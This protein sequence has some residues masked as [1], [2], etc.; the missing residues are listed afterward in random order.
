[1]PEFSMSAK[2]S[3]LSFKLMTIVLISFIILGTVV[4][5][6][7][8]V[9]SRKS[10]ET[11]NF[12]N[13]N[14]V[15]TSQI[16]Y[17]QNYFDML[18][19]TLTAFAAQEGTVIAVEEFIDS[20][21]N[22]FMY[23]EVNEQDMVES[24]TKMYSSQFVNEINYNILNSSEKKSI[25]SYMPDS[26]S[27]KLLQH[28]AI[29]KNPKPF[30]EKKDV[31]DLGVVSP[32]NTAHMQYHPSFFN[33]LKSFDVDDIFLIDTE[34]TVVYSVMKKVDF[35]T[36]LEFGPYKDSG[37]AE[38]YSEV[39]ELKKGEIAFADY[40]PYEPSKNKPASFMVTKIMIDGDLVG[41]MGFQLSAT[42]LE[43]IINFGGHFEKA[44]MGK[45]G[46]SYLVGPDGLFRSDSRFLDEIIK[47]DQYTKE[48]G[49]TVASFKTEN[50]EA[51][52]ALEGKS[53]N[54][55]SLDSF[56]NLSMSAY[57]PVKIFDTTWAIVVEKDVSEA[58]AAADSLRNSIIII[59]LVFT[60]LAVTFT[61]FAMRKLVLSKIVNLT[62]IT[63][64]IAT[65][66]GDLT[67]RIP[68]TSNDE[69]GELTE[70]FNR[71]IENV[72]TIVRD[73][74]VSADSVASGTT[75]LAAT[76]EELNMT[77]GEQ[78]S[79][80][81][82][83]ASAMEELNATTAEISESSAN[84][85]S[86][87]HESGEITETG[88]EKIEESVQK[89]RDIMEQTQLL[90]KTISNLSESSSQIAEILN[91]ID[92]IA[93][94][95][96]LLALNAAI[97]AARAGEAGRGFAVVADEVRKLAERTQKATGEISGI[98]NDF[99]SETESAS[100]NMSNAEASVN[101]GVEIMTETKEVFDTIVHSV[102]EIETANNSINSAITEQ[103]TTISSVT[104]EIQGL[105]SSVE[106]SSSAINEVT[107]TLSDQEQQ[108]EGLK[109]MVNRFKV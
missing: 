96:N 27:G 84:A 42:Q 1:M 16:D 102:Y 65:G 8:V 77:F 5:V 105:S 86:K 44:G 24:L 70:Y 88:K 109:Q 17:L 21:E 80:V 47:T 20:Y 94:Q 51:M 55:I 107:A 92:D 9:K 43:K 100:L 57:A 67:Q 3:S 79:N 97:E 73:V 95:T 6:F 68:V 48:S 98:I 93:D 106:Q 54:D 82:S 89:I 2:K 41:Y 38:A 76:T 75:E 45:T 87:A 63:K 32:Y 40:R 108:A 50:K 49:T 72:H 58:L 56:G 7:S 66:D 13:L 53:G 25:N 74:Q 104:A 52:E 83:V 90:G 64:N 30:G 12:N 19:K 103:M 39:K 35:A 101:A 60:I 36:N 23:Y 71:F 59:S 10:L 29:Y 37:L 33:L 85:L 78:S 14:A 61:V 91:V 46:Q 34:G 15:R 22:I 62:K 31:R 81:S 11:A 69:I 4:T 18:S 28:L 26:I 99:K